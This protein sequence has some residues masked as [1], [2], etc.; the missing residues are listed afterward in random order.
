MINCKGTH[1]RETVS[2][3]T[4]G[5]HDYSQITII[6]MDKDVWGSSQ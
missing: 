6:K 1:E 5:R 4:V 3:P 2:T